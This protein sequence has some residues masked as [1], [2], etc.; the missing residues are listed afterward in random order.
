MAERITDKLVK[1]LV[2]PAA[3]NRVVYD[4]EVRGFGIRI[5]ASGT[6]A[7]VLNYRHDA[8]G[9]GRR[10]NEFRVTVGGYPAWSVAAARDEARRLKQRI[11]KGE[12]PLAERQ[13]KRAA[14]KAEKLAETYEEAVEDYIKREQIGR[15][16]NTTAP[17]VRQSLLREGQPWLPRPIGSITAAEIR[18]R[19]EAIR[20]GDESAKPKPIKPRPYLANRHYAHLNAFFRWCLEPGIDLVKV[21]PM[22]GLRRP[23]EG[24]EARQRFYSDDE[25]QAIWRAADAIDGTAGAFV[26]VAM[27][28][29]KR[30]GALS[31]MRWAEIG[32]NG[33]WTPPPDPRQ[34]KRNK[35]VHPVPLPGLVQRIIAPLRKV[36]R[37]DETFV[38]AGRTAGSHLVPGSPLQ[39]RVAELSGVADFMPHGLRHSVETRMAELRIPPHIRDAVLDHAPARGSGGGYDHY[40][41]A[42][43]VRDALEAWAAH[44]ERV[45]APQGGRVLR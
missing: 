9:T 11:D 45:V 1:G 23:W 16:Q 15:R 43:E 25:L 44:V 29:G 18:R 40:S 22:I 21:N 7:F 8:A 19:L 27:L 20:D 35:R 6:R 30:R 34:R 24:E 5:T 32:E 33:T 12:N 17:Q 13:A 2:S 36:G 10:T 3:G 42:T 14:V 31:A 28:T 26:K 38:F 37:D 4:D 39:K 41:Y